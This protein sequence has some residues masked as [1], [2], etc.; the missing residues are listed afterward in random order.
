MTSSSRYGFVCIGKD[1]ALSGITDGPPE[2]A[3]KKGR[4]T[5]AHSES[6]SDHS[7][8][9]AVIRA[10]DLD[11][12]GFRDAL[13]KDIVAL[14]TTAINLI[15]AH[16][17]PEEYKTILAVQK[18]AYRYYAIQTRGSL[19]ELV[20]RVR[21]LTSRQMKL[22]VQ[23]S[24]LMCH[25]VNFAEWAH[26]V[27]RRRMYE[28]MLPK[29]GVKVAEDKQ[30]QHSDNSIFLTFDRLQNTG[31]PPRQI[32]QSLCN[33]QIEMVFTAHPTEAMRE[34][35]LKSLK[36]IADRILSLD[37]PDL[38]PTEVTLDQHEIRRAIEVLWET[39]PIRR[40]KPT[41]F[42]EA[43]GI[44]N[45]IED[46]VFEAV[47]LYLRQMDLRLQEIGQPPLPYTARPLKFASWAGGD[48]DGNPFVTH[49]VTRDIIISNYVRGTKLFLNKVGPALTP[50]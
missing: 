24:M 22:V 31:Y 18:L 39:D 12:V 35:S 1:S 45:A 5:R 15:G 50:H 11:H 3:E 14:K 9:T 16:V 44:A 8:V 13:L 4:L 43:A 49:T 28:R 17:T 38:T 23:I 42:T 19:D 25:L 27:R 41:V 47:P 26:R 7:P 33:Q 10:H 30:F 32:Y 48:R 6:P 20:D 40:R 2:T 37:R 36:T 21:H 46:M 29:L 34:A